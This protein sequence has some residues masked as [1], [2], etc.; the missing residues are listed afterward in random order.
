[1]K[2]LRKTGAEYESLAAEYLKRRGFRI[3]RRNF[4][5]RGGEIDLIALD[6]D[7][8]VFV[9]VKYR[10]T[11]TFGNPLEAVNATKQKRICRAASYFCVR[12]GYS[13][14]RSFRF[15]VVAILGNGKIT[16]VEN[17]FEYRL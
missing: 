8:L 10:R 17:A 11:D 1:M 3:I 9:E 6:G 14:D 12:Y 2:N 15:D 7:S 5:C 13:M 16:H 4:Y